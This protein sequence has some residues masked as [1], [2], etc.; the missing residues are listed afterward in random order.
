LLPAQLHELLAAT[1]DAIDALGGQ[2][3]M[4]YTTFVLTAAR[5]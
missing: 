2:F 4:P 3:T 1:G 5:A